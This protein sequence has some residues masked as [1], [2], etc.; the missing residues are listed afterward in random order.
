VKDHPVQYWSRLF[1]DGTINA[2]CR[3]ALLC[4]APVALSVSNRDELVKD[5]LAIFFISRMDDIEPRQIKETLEEWRNE[6]MDHEPDIQEERELQLDNTEVENGTGQDSQA[7]SA[8]RRDSRD[9][10]LGP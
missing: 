3:E 8:H 6:R 10:L 4:L 1:F 2:F 7:E 5:C 9:L